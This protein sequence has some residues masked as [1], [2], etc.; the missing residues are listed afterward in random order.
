MYGTFVGNLL[1]P[2]LLFFGQISFDSH[3]PLNAVNEAVGLIFAFRAVLAVNPL[4]SQTHRYAFDRPGFTARI[5]RYGHRNTTAEGT[6]QES[7][8]IRP[9]IFT[10][11]ATGSSVINECAAP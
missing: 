7:V 9:R 2:R 11:A 4:L 6:K 1:K 3:A 10:S 5:K 8:R